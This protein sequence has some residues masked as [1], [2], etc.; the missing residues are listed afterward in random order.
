MGRGLLKRLCVPIL[1]LILSLLLGCQ[2]HSVLVKPALEEEG[3]LVVYL[4]PLPQEAEPLA[5]ILEGISAERDEGGSYPLTLSLTEIRGEK[6]QRQ[7][8]LASADLPPGKYSGLS[9]KI[10]NAS[11]KGKKGPQPSLYRKNP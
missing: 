4:R 1:I 3:E 11:L 8:F 2:A 9:F 5:F 7:R 10:K 6:P